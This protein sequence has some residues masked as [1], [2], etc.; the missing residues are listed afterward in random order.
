MV[1]TRDDAA[2]AC[3]GRG[4]IVLMSRTDISNRITGLGFNRRLNREVVCHC[5]GLISGG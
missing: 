1:R 5:C 4:D 2:S 3:D